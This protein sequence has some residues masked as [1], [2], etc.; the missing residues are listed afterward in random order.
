MLHLEKVLQKTS[1]KT[2]LSK[3]AWPR[4]DAPEDG[5]PG[6]ASPAAEWGE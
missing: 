3:V 5:E 1:P 2:R 4:T 6:G